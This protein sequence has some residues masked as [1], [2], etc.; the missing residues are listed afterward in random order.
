MDA[1]LALIDLLVPYKARCDVS[2]NMRDMP[3]CVL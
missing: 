1:D 3:C 2:P